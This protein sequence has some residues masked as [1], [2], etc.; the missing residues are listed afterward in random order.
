MLLQSNGYIRL[1][2][3][4]LEAALDRTGRIVELLVAGSKRFGISTLLLVFSCGVQTDKFC[5]LACLMRNFKMSFLNLCNV[6]LILIPLLYIL[7]LL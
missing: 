6:I 4:F 2:N 7:Y 3:G 1:K 5:P